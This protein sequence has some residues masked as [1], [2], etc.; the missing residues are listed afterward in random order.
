[1]LPSRAMIVTLWL[2]PLS[3][4]P[5]FTIPAR[6]DL[7]RSWRDF[8]IRINIDQSRLRCE[9]YATCDPPKEAFMGGHFSPD[10]PCLICNKA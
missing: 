10:I 6:V 4:G 2:T 1:M 7:P 5:A 9:R 8:P 3:N